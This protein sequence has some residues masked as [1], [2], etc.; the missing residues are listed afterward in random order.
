MKKQ[1]FDQG[2]EFMESAG[3]MAMFSR[4]LWQK[5]SLLRR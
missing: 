1:N 4:M 5:A 2:W 3:L